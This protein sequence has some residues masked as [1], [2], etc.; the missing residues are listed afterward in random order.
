MGSLK[1]FQIKIDNKVLDY[2]L[3]K[4]LDLDNIRSFFKKDY[5]VKKLWTGGRHIFGLLEKRK[6]VFFLKLST[7]E[8]IS[9]LTKNEYKWNDEFNKL[10][11]RKLFRFWVPKNEDSGFYY[12]NLFYLLTDNFEGEL[13]AEKPDQL[14]ISSLFLNSINHIIEFS[15]LIQELRLADLLNNDQD[16]KQWFFDK[17]NSWFE[18]IPPEI[19]KRYAVNSLLDIVEKNYPKLVKKAHHGDFTPWHLMKLKSGQIG[20]LDGEHAKKNGVE[21]YDIGY[22]IQRIFS[23]LK[24]QD[25]AEKLLSLLIKKNYQIEKLI[26]ILAARGIGGF[27]DESL[28]PSPNYGYSNKFKNWVISIT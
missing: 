2:R 7:T 11:S 13:L 23:V 4:Q 16:S 1:A 25:F 15:K 12:G 22:F 28:K 19:I 27:L 17:T 24:N 21:Y 3:G 26:V 14:Q 10:V 6:R 8:G 9:E 20:L 18:A 5:S